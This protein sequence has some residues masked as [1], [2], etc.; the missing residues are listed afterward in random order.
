MQLRVPRARRAM[1]ERRGHQTIRRD[2][3]GT[4]LAA[5]MT[6]Q[7][8]GGVPLQVAHR[9]VDRPLM[10][11]QDRRRDGWLGQ[12]VENG[13]ALR[14]GHSQVQ[15][16]PAYV[17]PHVRLPVLG[18]RP[19][20]WSA[21]NGP[22]GQPAVQQTGERGLRVAGD[23][24]L[25]AERG[26]ALTA[27][28]SLRLGSAGVIRRGAAIGRPLQVVPGGAHAAA[29]HRNRDHRAHPSRS[30]QRERGA[31]GSFVVRFTPER[32]AGGAPLASETPISRVAPRS[33]WSRIF[34]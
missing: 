13:N 14:R 24:A 8:V 1:G 26:R 23:P 12:S 3:G 18:A 4:G 15:P 31:V 20:Y 27:P 34:A 9:F 21:R 25:Q 7:T 16:G 19:P 33:E 2:V 10:R 28:T 11:P 17:H 32:S 22:V 30:R 6:A 29:Q 5:L